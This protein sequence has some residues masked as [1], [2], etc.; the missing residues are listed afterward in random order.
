[1]SRSCCCIIYLHFLTRYKI[2]M[3]VLRTA[4][5]ANQRVSSI[6]QSCPSQPDAGKT[7]ISEYST[8]AKAYVRSSLSSTVLQGM[9]P[10]VVGVSKSPTQTKYLGLSQSSSSSSSTDSCR[11]PSAGCISLSWNDPTCGFFAP[12]YLYAASTGTFFLK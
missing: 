8:R 1:M 6:T 7:I 2:S 3:F 10:R 5:N 12:S 9:P 11:L 4:S